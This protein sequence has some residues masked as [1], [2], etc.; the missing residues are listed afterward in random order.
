MGK[1]V[2][3]EQVVVA[4]NANGEATANTTLAQ[5]QHANHTIETLLIVAV[6]LISAA[7]AFYILKKCRKSAINS[8]RQ[9]L[10]AVSI[11]NLARPS[12]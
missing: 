6:T 5:T 10:N 11:D 4:Q 3:K 1:T 8:L 7:V 2:S 9:E 12:N